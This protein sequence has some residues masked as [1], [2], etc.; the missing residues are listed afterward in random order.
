M[1]LHHAISLIGDRKNDVALE[2]LHSLS[3]E[4]DIGFEVNYHLGLVYAQKTEYLTALN[5]YEKALSVRSLD[6]AERQEVILQCA[7][8]ADRAGQYDKALTY[9]QEIEASRFTG[10][11]LKTA[12]QKRIY[13]IKLG[14][15]S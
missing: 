2:I 10:D 4:T 13:E 5:W 9:Y 14:N 3:S 1:R 8:V 12:I 15:L 6:H 7:I 11:T